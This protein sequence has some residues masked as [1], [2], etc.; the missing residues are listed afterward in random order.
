M[1]LISLAAIAKEL[2]VRGLRSRRIILAVGLPIG[3]YAAEKND[4]IR[5]LSRDSLYV[6]KVINDA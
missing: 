1:F 4:F 6:Q 5:Y 3:R 2:K